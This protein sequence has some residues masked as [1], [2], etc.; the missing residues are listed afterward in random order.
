[1]SIFRVK[2]WSVHV[3]LQH[4]LIPRRHL[5]DSIDHTSTS[6]DYPLKGYS[7]FLEIGSFYN[8]LRV[9]QLGFTV[10]ELIQPIFWYLDEYQ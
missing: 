6:N 8:S 3:F 10:F 5:T 1:M 7:T 4:I 2:N 9:K